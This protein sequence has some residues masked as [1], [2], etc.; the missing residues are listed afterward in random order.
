MPI[1]DPKVVLQLD[2]LKQEVAQMR[3][4]L[5]VMVQRIEIATNYYNSST[6][7]PRPPEVLPEFDPNWSEAVQIKWFDLMIAA[8]K[9]KP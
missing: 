4:T 8:N 7:R 2:E 5:T 6:P 3:R 1:P 9:L